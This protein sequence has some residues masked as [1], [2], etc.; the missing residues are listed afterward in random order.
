MVSKTLS[1]CP[2]AYTLNT[3]TKQSDV[4]FVSIYCTW[5]TE[6]CLANVHSTNRYMLCDSHLNMH[7]TKRLIIPHRRFFSYW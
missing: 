7:L 2:V 4:A 5:H 1:V 6:K 3:D